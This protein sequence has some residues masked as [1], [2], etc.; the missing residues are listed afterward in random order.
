MGRTKPTDY[1]KLVIYKI[2]CNDESVF[3]FYVG[4][5][6]HFRGRKCMHKNHSETRNQKIY[7]TIRA[8]GGWSNWTMVEIEKYPCNSSTEARIREEY[9]RE[10]L[11]ANLNMIRAYR[12]EEI[13]KIYQKQYREEHKDE[14]KKYHKQ[15][16]Q[17]HSEKILQTVK[18]YYQD[19]IDKIKKKHSES[20]ECNCGVTYT[21][22]NKARHERS[23]QHQDWLKNKNINHSTI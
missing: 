10:T 22:R 8:N 20:F 4:S 17:E 7:E 5:T 12:S 6:T 9:W 19:N 11:Q 1:L 18:Q 14:M 15:Y 13:N 16:H 3:D 21:Y 23:P 2:K